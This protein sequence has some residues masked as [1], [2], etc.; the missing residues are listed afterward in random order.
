MKLYFSYKNLERKLLLLSVFFTGGSVL[1]IEIIAMRILSPY[2]GNTLYTTSSVISVVLAALSLGYYWGGIIA[3]KYPRYDIF[4]LIIFFSG[5]LTLFTQFLYV[6]LLPIIALMFSIVI[7]PLISAPLLFFLPAFFLGILSPFAIKLYQTDSE[8]IGSN[9]GKIFFCSTFGSIVGSLLCGFLLIPHIGITTIVIGTGT[10]LSAW[11]FIGFLI[12]RLKIFGQEDFLKKNK[13]GMIMLILLFGIIFSLAYTDFSP[14]ELGVVFQKD[15]VYEKITIKNDVWLGQPVRSLMQDKSSS[16]AMYLNSSDLV[17]DYTKYYALYQLFNLN[18]KR[19]F[20]IGGGAY[21]IPKALLQDTPDVI[22][23]VT[24]IEPELFP[25]ARQYFNL[26]DDPRLHNY[27]QD[28]RYFLKR[29][30]QK[31]DVMVSDVYYSFFSIPVQFTTKEFFDLAKSKLETDGVF[32]GNF[33]GDL[34]QVS[35]SFILSEMKTFKEVFPNSYFFA[36]VD[37]HIQQGQNI[38][39]LGINGPQNIDFTGDLVLNNKNP[40]LRSLPKKNIDISNFDFN[41]H[42]EITDNFAPVEY[43]ISKVIDQWHN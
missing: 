24:E 38:I 31:Y 43:Y 25:L 41:R 15:G 20:I 11:G 16:A 33:A 5:L 10:L 29:T 14:R 8:H 6:V 27:T 26:A 9:S 35:P 22:I 13:E 17:Y 32:V 39:F 3:D 12:Y 28:G 18:P 36:V 19:A 2:F 21:S 1:V 30:D 7:G 34:R 40:I 42:K 23:D 37:P 4:Y